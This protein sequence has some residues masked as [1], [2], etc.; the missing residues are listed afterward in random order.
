MS[1]RVV[2]R[3]ILMNRLNRRSKKGMLGTLA[4]RLVGICRWMGRLSRRW[5]E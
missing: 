2:E 5:L 3:R 1:S 4:G